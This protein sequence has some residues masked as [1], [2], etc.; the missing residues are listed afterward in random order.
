[1]DHLS[2]GKLGERFAEAILKKEGYSILARNARTPRGEIDIVAQDR[3]TVC[4]IEVK[5]R[6]TDSFGTPE[7]AVTPHK[8][9]KIRSA[10]RAFLAQFSKEPLSCRFDVVA[11][12][13]NGKG[14]LVESRI[15]KD[16]FT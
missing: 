2:L 11:L 9:A 1:M 6:R 5:A 14:E 4:F 16:A 7:E 15:I 8:R 10:A 13:I 12:T 3:D